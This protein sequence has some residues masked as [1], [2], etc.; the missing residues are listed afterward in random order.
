MGLGGESYV[1]FF[2]P[3]ARVCAG[4]DRCRGGSGMGHADRRIGCGASTSGQP[5]T[6]VDFRRQVGHLCHGPYGTV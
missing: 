1:H 3:C 2:L 6:R 5:G 4:M